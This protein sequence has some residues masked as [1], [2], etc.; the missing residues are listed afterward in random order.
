MTLWSLKT[1]IGIMNV[2][3]LTWQ[4][5]D[6]AIGASHSLQGRHVPRRAHKRRNPTPIVVDEQDSDVEE[7]GLNKRKKTHMMMRTLVIKKMLLV[8]PM[9]LEKTW[10][11]LMMSLMMDIKCPA[12]EICT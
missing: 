10:L 9:L 6:C 7:L 3:A 4:M 2:D 8:I 11:L 12:Q 1:S 5:V